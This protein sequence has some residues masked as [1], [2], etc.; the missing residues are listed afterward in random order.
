M[1]PSLFLSQNS[2]LSV[3]GFLSSSNLF[4]DR[5]LSLSTFLSLLLSPSVLYVL[6]PSLYLKTSFSSPTTMIQLSR[7]LLRSPLIRSSLRSSLP[8]SLSSRSSRSSK[9]ISFPLHLLSPR[10]LSLT[11]SPPPPPA[12]SPPTPP[13]PPS[14]PPSLSSLNLIYLSEPQLRVRFDGW[15]G[16]GDGVLDEM[17]ARGILEDAR[18]EREIGMEMAPSLSST[19]T[20]PTASSSSS[21]TSPPPSPGL[22]LIRSLSSSSTTSTLTYPD[23][24]SAVQTSAS[25][26]DPRIYPISSSL[27]LNFTGQGVILPVLPVLARTAGLTATELGV[28]TA[29]AAAARIVSNVPAAHFAE[30]FGRRPLLIYG[31]LLSSLGMLSFGLSDTTGSSHDSLMQFVLANSLAGCGGAMTSAGAGLYLA[32]I[33]TPSN[34]A[35]TMAPLMVTALLGFAAGPA[36]G[37]IVAEFHGLHAPF[38]ITAGGMAASAAA[39]AKFLP[40]TRRT[41]TH[42]PSRGQDPPEKETALTQ[43]KQML[44]TSP[45]QGIMSV[46]AMTGFAQGASPVTSVLYAT[47]VLGMSPGEVG[48]MFTACVLGMAVVVQPATVYSDKMSGGCRSVLILPGLAVAA[49]TFGG[50]AYCASPAPFIAL[51]VLRALADAAFIMPSVTP[52]IIDNTAESERA[53]ALAMR[54]MSQDVGILLG[55]VS[56]GA[57]SQYYGVATAMLCTAGMQAGTAGFFAERTRGGRGEAEERRREEE[58][59][60]G[61]EE[62]EAKEMKEREKRKKD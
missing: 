39:A 40:E 21:S 46:A 35:R 49:A 37:G 29:A 55:A 12:D 1:S 33:S 30:R 25:P 62:E 59:M 34:R 57:V 58:K 6:C 48:G 19:S 13:P 43:W 36:L 16:N 24:L 54:N 51:A 52:Y 38:F 17:E 53:Q 31:P 2:F 42:L 15:D 22:N 11:S 8:S 9:H 23:F 3:Q 41:E 4:A 60:R 45:L 56:M 50:Q 10:P 20:L 32:D 27:L 61:E 26:V 5:A 7:S 44:S 28:V 14:L 18:V 47:E